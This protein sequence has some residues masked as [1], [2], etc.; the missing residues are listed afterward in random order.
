MER[1]PCIPG[2]KGVLGVEYQTFAGHPGSDLGVRAAP[3]QARDTVLYLMGGPRINH[4]PAFLGINLGKVGSSSPS[5]VCPYRLLGRLIAIKVEEAYFI[6]LLLLTV[7]TD[8]TCRAM[9][10][11]TDLPVELLQHI[12][13]YLGHSKPHSTRHL[14]EEP[15]EALLNCSHHPIKDLSLTCNRLYQITFPILY[16]NLKVSIDSIDAILRFTTLHS[17][18][19]KVSTLLLHATLQQVETVMSLGDSTFHYPWIRIL[20][21]IDGVDP[22][23]VTIL[24]PPAAFEYILP[25]SLRLSDEWAFNI[26]YQILHLSYVRSSTCP[27]P[28]ADRRPIIH[29]N[30]LRIRPWTYCTYNQGSSI[31]AYSTYEYFH[32]CGP[33]LINGSHPMSMF[34]EIE[35]SLGHLLIFDFIAIFPFPH[36]QMHESYAHDLV[37]FLSSIAPFLR[38]LRVQLAPTTGN[39]ILDDAKALGTCQRSDLWN[40]FEGAVAHLMQRLKGGRLKRLTNFTLLDYENPWRRDMINDVIHH[41]ADSDEWRNKW[42]YEGGGC[43]VK[44]E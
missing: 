10:I 34:H 14:H 42:R 5:S 15:S 2:G 26:P 37:Y 20:A 38:H 39:N 44:V 35:G 43:Y 9:A 24:F 31:H 17:L 6:D 32:K 36:H 40:E 41:Y 4:F 1:F 22:H 29:Q 21:L 8:P 7:E 30:I 16:T 3:G 25:Y 12:I 28:D 19:A 13:C 27:T 23:A 33:S 11:L 18:T